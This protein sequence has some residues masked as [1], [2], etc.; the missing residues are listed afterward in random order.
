MHSPVSDTPDMDSASHE[1]RGECSP[2]RHPE[3]PSSNRDEGTTYPETGSESVGGGGRGSGRLDH[4]EDGGMDHVIMGGVEFDGK[5]EVSHNG[6]EN[7]LDHDQKGGIG[8]DRR[9]ERTDHV[10]QVGG[11]RADEG[12]GEGSGGGSGSDR[13][14]GAA[15]ETEQ[16]ASAGHSTKIDAPSY[17]TQL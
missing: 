3:A 1:E 13:Y 6:Q 5:V 16:L 14:K 7:R 9:G 10:V 11:G 12:T 4:E 8:H 15:I 2:L 17:P